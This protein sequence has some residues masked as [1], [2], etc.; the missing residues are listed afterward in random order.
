MKASEVKKLLRE[1]SSEEKAKASMWFFKTGKEG[2]AKNDRFIGVTVPEQRKIAK[3]A[4]GSPL[5]E[6]KKLLDSKIHEERLTALFIL[7]YK[8]P[9]K[10]IFNFYMK[11]IKRVDNW[12][13]V[14][15][16]AEYIVGPYCDENFLINLAKS[17]NIWERRIAM[18]ATFHFIKQG[19]FDLT[20]KVAEMLLK[21]EEDLIQK[22]VGWMLREVGKRCSE[23]KLKEFLKQHYNQMARTTL[24]Y[25]IERFPEKE[26]MAFI[27]KKF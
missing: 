6:V 27:E 22:A 18:I 14:D 9:S 16:S 17:S 20:L 5:V 21:D 23:E 7:V 13:L 25:A 19:E 10:K 4:V 24:R 12:D 3:K 8:T 26:R 11:N 15:C 2:Y 1:V